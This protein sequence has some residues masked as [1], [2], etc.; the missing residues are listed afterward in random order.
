MTPS[1][2]RL[3]RTGGLIAIAVG[4]V[5]SVGLTLR[6]GRTAPLILQVLFVIWVL[7]PFV[8]AGLAD[9]ASKRWLPL[10]SAT[11][12]VGSLLLTLGS[13]AIYSELIPRPQGSP[14]A[15]PFVVVPPV[16]CVLVAIAVSIAALLSR[17]RAAG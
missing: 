3:L 13:L 5:G 4:A 16:S 17:R 1:V 7:G 8:A 14:V 12:H 11:L 15:A 10:T 9:V 6:A 2:L